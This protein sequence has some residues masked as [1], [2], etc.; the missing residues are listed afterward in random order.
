LIELRSDRFVELQAADV[1]VGWARK[2]LSENGLGSLRSYFDYITFN[3]ER[4]TGEN[5]Q[6]VQGRAGYIILP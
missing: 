1:A 5:L 3:G 2:V 4:L 6:D